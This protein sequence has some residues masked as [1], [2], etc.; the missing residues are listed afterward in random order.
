MLAMGLG[1]CV[2]K[3][4]SAQPTTDDY[5][6]ALPITNPAMTQPSTTTVKPTATTDEKTAI[7]STSL[8]DIKVAFYPEPV[9]TVANF[10]KLASESF[11]D[12]VTFHRVISGFMIQSGDPLSKDADWSNDGRGGPGYT[13]DDE[14]NDHLLVKGSLAMANAG[15]NTNGSQFFIVTAEATPWLDGKH[16]NFGRVIEGMEVVDKINSVETNE[17]DHPLEDVVIKSIKIN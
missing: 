17:N 4:P 5:L 3:P 9:K 13:F 12:G 16:T 11:Y 10:T 15:P 1:G 14:I 8:G 6:N 2:L 7:I